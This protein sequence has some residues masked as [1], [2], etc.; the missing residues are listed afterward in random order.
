MQLVNGL[1]GDIPEIFRQLLAP[2]RRRDAS[3]PT[4]SIN[5]FQELG[6]TSFL[7][8]VFISPLHPLS[9]VS[10]A[11]KAVVR[12]FVSASAAIGFGQ[13]AKRGVSTAI[14]AHQLKIQPQR[15]T[16][17]SCAVQIPKQSL[18]PTFRRGYADQP[19]VKE[20]TKRRSRGFFR[21]TWRL[22][23]L[24]AIGGL[25][26]TGYGVYQGKHPA[27]QEEP[28]PKKKTLVVL[29]MHA[30]DIDDIDLVQDC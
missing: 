30:Q 13:V 28:D 1:K 16:V 23:Y 27:D 22:F 24:S 14:R 6:A 15:N 20:K 3:G 8:Q 11:S 4:S 7:Q 10:M 5:C 17:K 21:W 12:P 18:Q 9:L 2:G 25:I 26:W 19:I 29:G